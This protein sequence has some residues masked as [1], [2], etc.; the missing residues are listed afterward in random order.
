[1]YT[2]LR[3]TRIKLKQKSSIFICQ[4]DDHDHV[5][6]DFDEKADPTLIADVVHR[7]DVKAS[8]LK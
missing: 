5:K 7:H 2:R 4:R 8:V 1:M 3:A 6:I